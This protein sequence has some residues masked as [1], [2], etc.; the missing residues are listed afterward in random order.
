MT[1]ESF[2]V[3]NLLF[4]F[5]YGHTPLHLA[6]LSGDVSVVEALTDVIEKTDKSQLFVCDSDENSALHLAAAQKRSLEMMKL[7]TA[8][9]SSATNRFGET[10][11]HV[12]ARSDH[13]A[14]MEQLALALQGH[15][16][17]FNMDASNW[18]TGDTALHVSARRGDWHRVEQLIR[19]GAD[20][21]ARNNEGNT[22]LHVI[23]LE[24]ANNPTTI[25]AYIQ[26]CV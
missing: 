20:L 18:K 26:V 11:F 10:P 25:D 24:C 12:A 2:P 4:V 17:K 23:V 15:G 7:L 5:R 3:A 16:R 19:A 8:I 6:I 13:D 1:L 21:A 14:S 22:V 9:D